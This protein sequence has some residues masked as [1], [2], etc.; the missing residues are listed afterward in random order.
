MFRFADKFDYTMMVVGTLGG[1]ALGA[2]TPVFILFWGQFTDVFS[3][4]IDV[5][6]EEA[7]NQLLKFIY[8]GI[9][10]LL[11]GWAMVTGWTI[12][13]ERQAVACRKAYFASLLRQEIGWFDCINQS[14]LSSNFSAD[15][16]T[17][18]G[19][20]GEKMAVMLQ[21]IGTGIGG[22][23]VAFSQG[24]LMTLVCLAGIPI[25][26]LSGALYMRSLQMKA[27]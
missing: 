13:G 26:A 19:A 9:G 5:I 23:A 25:I 12:T 16:L 3:S 15:T 22:F 6:V 24:W 17:F 11:L 27:K 14:G 2:S 1:L 8:L 7:K 21:A 4:N 10:A 18:Q 20:L